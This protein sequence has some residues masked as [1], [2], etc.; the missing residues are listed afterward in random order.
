VRYPGVLSDC[1]TC[2]TDD[3]Y[4]LPLPEGRLPT[5]LEVR[6]CVEDPAADANDFCN[7]S[8]WV[9]E[10]EIIMQPERAVC[11]SCHDAPSTDAHAQVMTTAMGDESCSTCHG[12]GS[13]SDVA[14]VHPFVP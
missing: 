3:T 14:R 12:P 2:H 1:S 5:P 7:D 11:T 6:N 8:D 9:V 13:A 10:E 4:Q